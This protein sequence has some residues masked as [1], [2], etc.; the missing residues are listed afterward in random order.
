[1]PGC[2]TPNSDQLFTYFLAGILEQG[3]DYF[4]E[5][6]KHF[7]FNSPE[8]V[9]TIQK[10]M[11]MA[12]KDGVVDPI[13]FNADSEW[14]GEFVCAG[15]Y[16]DWRAG[17]LVRG[18]C[19]NRLSRSEV[20]LCFPTTHDGQ[21]AQVRFGRRLG[22]CGRKSTQHPD[23]AWKLASFL[24]ADQ[25]NAFNFNSISATIPAMKAVAADPALVVAA[26]FMVSVLL[27]LDAGQYQG[28][29]TDFDQ[30]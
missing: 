17:F 23:E 15:A 11:D 28:D 18:R 6:G 21:R 29:L 5:D 13:I 12:Q 2:I 25:A 9:A 10:L 27:F 8:A 30:L 26:P 7:V 24:G 16:V 3:A 22:L 20:R 19:E 1:M 14:V 4:A